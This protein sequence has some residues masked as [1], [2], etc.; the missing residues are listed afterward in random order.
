MRL[1]R[2]CA[3]ASAVAASWGAAAP[4][5]HGQAAAA[6]PPAPAAPAIERFTVQS[7]GHPIAVWARKPATPK[8]AILLIHGRTWSSRPDFDLQVPGLQRSVLVSFVAQGFAAYAMDLRGYGETP[9][10]K[11]GW[12]TPLR[13]AT[14]VGN[15]A[16]WVAAQHPSLPKPALV[17][18][19]RGG[20]IA[21]MAAQFSP[22]R[23]SALVLFGFVFDPDLEFLDSVSSEKPQMS[24]NTEESAVSDFVSPKVTPPAVIQAFTE[25]AMKADPILM[26]LKNDA[27]FNALKPA[28]LT[29]PTLILYGERDGG[30]LP[31]D[32]G[33][34]FARLAASDKQMVVLPGSDHAAH[35]EDTHEAWIAAIVNFLNRPG[36]KR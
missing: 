7:D 27:E 17:G 15:V 10:D 22:A 19:S 4:E 20:A 30:V 28:K 36:L 2:V 34:F 24:K 35:L 1:L 32:A 12:L 23:V 11:T 8:G 9:R 33:K 26:D 3:F 13:A 16:A 29:T 25:Q 14:D 31:D 21:A 18:W 6:R 5:A